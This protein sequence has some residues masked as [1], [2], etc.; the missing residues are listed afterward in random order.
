MAPTRIEKRTTTSTNISQPQFL[1]E[2]FVEIA[3]MSWRIFGT[4]KILQPLQCLLVFWSQPVG[5]TSNLDQVHLHMIM[6]DDQTEVLN[7]QLLKLTF[8]WSQVELML[9]EVSEN[10]PDDFPVTGEV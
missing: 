9:P 6:G 3:D 1:L 7:R 2:R 5:N 4:L 10:F 8:L